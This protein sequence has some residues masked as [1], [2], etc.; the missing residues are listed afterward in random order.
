MSAITIV[1][2]L[3]WQPL[4]LL[5]IPASLIPWQW[6]LAGG[7]V[8]LPLLA[9]ALFGAPWRKIRDSE[10]LHVYLAAIVAL[11]LLW[12]M[13]GGI[14]AG[15]H[16][17]LLGVTLLTLMFE[18][19]FALLAA[20]LVIAASTVYAGLGW[21]ALGINILFC[22]ALPI[23]FTRL[24]LYVCQRRLPHN[25]F[26]YVFVNAFFGG[27]LALML[28]GAASAGW[29]W[30]IGM[31]PARD[32]IDFVQILPLLMFGEGFI[33]GGTLA[34]VVA[35]RPRWVATFHDHWYLRH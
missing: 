22:G 23:G 12:A 3:R 9:T 21:A 35:Y 20:S 27:A 17:H 24:L 34:L 31:Q 5:D 26:V 32:A 1:Y 29:Q 16:F 28:A 13:R 19:Q 7:V 10:A 6:S 30:A 15:L 2:R 33:N 11:C 14:H 18:W 4:P 25:Y 8:T